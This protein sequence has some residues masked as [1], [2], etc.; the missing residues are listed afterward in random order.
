M[1]YFPYYPGKI[2]PEDTK[3][4][5]VYD[6]WV[7]HYIV[8][9]RIVYLCMCEDAN[10]RRIPF[11]F[12]DDIKNKFVNAYSD[13]AMTAIAFSLNDEFSRVLQKQMEYFNSPAGDAFATV[14]LKL[15]DVKNVMMQNIDIVL[16]R[17]E[18]LEILVEKTEQLNHQAFIFQ[19]S[20]KNLKSAM[21]WKRIRFYLLIFL[22]IALIVWIL[23]VI[24]C[25]IT[26]EKCKK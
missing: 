3:M 5:Y 4:S 12:L 16:E 13:R 21:I 20:A 11:A 7:F 25:G 17:G 6:Q 18:K 8:E 2:G 22:V 26:Y 10:K 9:N 15:D 24:I 14:N 1:M 23:T 19:K